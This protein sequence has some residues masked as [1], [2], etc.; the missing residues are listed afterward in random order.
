[1]IFC[2][3]LLCYWHFRSP[4]L[5][6]QVTASKIIITSVFSSI[7]VFLF[8][9]NQ[10]AGSKV[11]GRSL[12]VL[13]RRSS[14]IDLIFLLVKMYTETETPLQKVFYRQSFFLCAYY[15]ISKCLH[16]IIKSNQI[17]TFIQEK[18]YIHTAPNSNIPTK[19]IVFGMLLVNKDSV[20]CSRGVYYP[21]MRHME[22]IEP[23]PLCTPE[24]LMPLML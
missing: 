11:V 19:K 12:R 5:R 3:T 10:T 8:S 24:L 13:I 1:M 18:Q 15:R 22:N 7:K 4:I 23:H 6:N 14:F 17:S 16:Q 21:T 2:I 9:K 20:K